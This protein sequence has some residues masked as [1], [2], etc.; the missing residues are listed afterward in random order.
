M[1]QVGQIFDSFNS[2]FNSAVTALVPVYGNSMSMQTSNTTVKI[3]CNKYWTQR[4]RFRID[5]KTDRDG[6]CV[7]VDSSTFVHNHAPAPEILADPSWRPKIR[8]DAA[9][10]ALGIAP[11]SLEDGTR[12]RAGSWRR[13][14]KGSARRGGRR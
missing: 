11:S 9:R 6:N 2:V 7:V 10:R 14:G 5:S 4:C 1:P 3:Y 12:V 13:G 8:G